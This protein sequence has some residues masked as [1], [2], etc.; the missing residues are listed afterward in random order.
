MLKKTISYLD[1]D[2]NPQVKT[3]WFNI[4]QSEMM[5]NLTILNEFQPISKIFEGE[6]RTLSVEENQM[7]FLFIKRL[8][9]LSYGLREE[10]NAF[11]MEIFPKALMAS[12]Q[13]QLKENPNLSIE[14][15]QLPMEPS[16]SK[17]PKQPK[18]MTR[19]E[20]MAAMR[21]RSDEI[22]N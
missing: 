6:K 16:E 1:L 18:D 17:G 15:I 20:L 19:E 9:Q 8:V 7:I 14:D 3:L 21:S 12:A 13:K 2:E 5:E 4:N 11:M 10:A 22:N